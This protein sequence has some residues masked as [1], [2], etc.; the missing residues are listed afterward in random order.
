M[1]ARARALL[2]NGR[3]PEAALQFLA[4]TLTNKLLHAPSANLRAAARRGDDELL[5]AAERLFDTGTGGANPGDNAA[6][7]N[8]SSDKLDKDA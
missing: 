3:D 2:A 5:R 4:N 7:D 1:L 6:S 8:S